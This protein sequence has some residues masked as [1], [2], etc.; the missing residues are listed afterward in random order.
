MTL[1][2]LFIRVLLPPYT[3]TEK[4]RLL[5][6]AVLA[7]KPSQKGK[8]V[9]KCYTTLIATVRLAVI[10]SLLLGKGQQFSGRKMPSNQT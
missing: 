5:H 3:E 7:S 10:C 9:L 2:N 1:V 4:D 6:F 8:D